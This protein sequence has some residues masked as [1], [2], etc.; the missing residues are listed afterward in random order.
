MD[1]SFCPTVSFSSPKRGF[2]FGGKIHTQTLAAVQVEVCLSTVT[3]YRF[4]LMR[5]LL[6]SRNPSDY[7]FPYQILA[8]T[9][10]VLPEIEPIYFSTAGRITVAYPSVWHVKNVCIEAGNA[11]TSK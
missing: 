9:S 10:L 6:L 3:Y 2:L 7:G 8:P 11:T 4:N 5:V 1:S